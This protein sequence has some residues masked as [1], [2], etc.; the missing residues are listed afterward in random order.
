MKEWGDAGYWRNDV[1]NYTGDTREAL[2]AG[3][4]GLDGHHTQTYAGLRVDMDE[5][6][7]DPICRCFRCIYRVVKILWK[8]L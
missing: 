2:K 4:T 5:K 3:Q 7:P 1:L 8:C 6:Q